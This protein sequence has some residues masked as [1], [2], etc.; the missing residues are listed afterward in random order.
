MDSI[1]LA[2]A[3][4]DGEVRA[5]SWRE[6]RGL[7]EPELYAGAAGHGAK[8][9]Q[10][11]VLGDELGYRVVFAGAGYHEEGLGDVG[12]EVGGDAD[13]LH[14]IGALDGD[15]QVAAGLLQVLGAE[16]GGGVAVGA[17]TQQGEADAGA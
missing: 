14:A 8:S 4:A 7:L 17:E 5:L 13:A 6:L 2:L 9:Y 10:I 15:G 3:R 11:W 12:Q 16:E 1:V